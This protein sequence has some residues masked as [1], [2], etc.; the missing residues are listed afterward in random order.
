MNATP[1]SSSR[2]ALK[3]FDWVKL[4]RHRLNQQIVGSVATTESIVTLILTRLLGALI[5][6]IR[7][8]E[9]LFWSK[10]GELTKEGLVQ[11]VLDL[12]WI[13]EA[14]SMLSLSTPKMHRSIEA[15]VQRALLEFC[16]VKGIRNPKDVLPGQNYFKEIIVQQL[17]NLK[18]TQVTN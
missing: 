7:D 12:R 17:E 4:F 1:S 8:C 14:S 6:Q 9:D 13:Q 11:F 10:S 5:D 16:N 2:Q 15:S 3:L 18:N